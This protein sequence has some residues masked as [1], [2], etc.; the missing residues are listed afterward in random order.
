MDTPLAPQG[1]PAA[2]AKLR[3]YET[4]LGAVPDLLYVF[5]R[6]HR[7]IY[8]NQALL[9]M[10]GL[11]WEQAQGRTCLELGYEPWHAAMHDEEIER[12]VATRAP[13][14]NDVPFHHSS[15]GWRFYDYIFMPVLGPDG[16]VEAIAGTTRD[17]T[18][19]K[20]QEEA[21]R[22]SEQ[23]LRAIVDAS[24]D[25]IYR[26]SP[27]WQ[28]IEILG[29]RAVTDLPRGQSIRWSSDR[30]H[31]EDKAR[32]SEAMSRARQTLTPYQS[33]H[34]VALRQDE[35]TWIESRA[36]PVHG[37][38]GEVTEWFGAATDVTQRVRHEE[39]LQLL[40]DELNHRVKNT[41]A[42]VQSLVAQT[43][44]TCAD[45]REAA[46]LIESRLRTLASTHDMLTREKWTGA[47]IPEIV[48][49]AMGHCLDGEAARFD[50][51]GPDVS[52][53][54]R[55]AV[56]LSMA[57]HELCTNATKY[58]ALSTPG[59]RVRI[60]WTVRDGDAQRRLVLEWQ[61]SGG[62]PVSAPAHGGFGTRLL[63]RG[64]QHDLGGTVALDFPVA[65]VRCHVVAPL[66]QSQ[67]SA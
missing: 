22:R 39:H 4:I 24:S 20:R 46:A 29:G 37:R 35:W 44:R 2:H 36:V 13:I 51:Q 27:D 54:P 48:R 56:A 34:R 9:D 38:E 66:P 65:G 32:M 40:V 5:D 30:I 57:L 19:R 55:R 31:P 33:Q 11:D 17:V 8:A 10:W 28:E 49:L 67:E 3:L 50:V 43:L 42:I 60:H 26:L 63:Q 23:R 58:G 59:G 7:F 64:L 47:S 62:P 18:D 16:E 53:D 52:L 41:L 6:Q 61:E 21:M 12:V 1:D 25:L 45:S 14:R 15:L